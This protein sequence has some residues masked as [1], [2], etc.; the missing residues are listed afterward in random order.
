LEELAP[1]PGEDVK[2]WRTRVRKALLARRVAATRE[3]HSRWCAAIDAQLERL[4]ETLPRGTVAFCWPYRREHDARPTVLRLLEKGARAAL[5]VVVAPRTPLDFREW[6]PG[7]EMEDDPHGIP[8]PTAKAARLAPD[9]VLLPM[10]GFDAAG[11]RLGYGS[12]FFDRTL[13]SLERR[14][15]VVG[16]GFE[17]G[18]LDSIRPQPHDIPLDCIVTE[19]GVWPRSPG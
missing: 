7:C 2:A 19:R 11:Y 17:I 8:M 18:R 9:L 16:I 14:P 4:L 15:F 13:A 1:A 5:P 12:G 3:D 6:R 10:I